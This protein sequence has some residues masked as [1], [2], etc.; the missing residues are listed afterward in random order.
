MNVFRLFEE[1]VAGALGRLADAGDIPAGLAIGRV[2][3]EPPRDPSHG[4]LATN[5]AMVLAKDAKT[6]PRALA[7]KIAA[8]LRGDERVAKVDV[9]GPGFINLTLA[10]GVFLDVLR[11]AVAAGADFGR[12]GVDGPKV[13][14]EYVSAN[15]TGPMHVGHGRGAVF[16][17]ALANLLVFAGRDVTREY[18]INDAGA[19]VD[20]LARSAF[21]R[22]RE[23]LGEDVEIPEGLYPGDYLKPV[24]Q[25]LLAT[26]GP[27]LLE[28]K[29]EAWLPVVRDFAI[30]AMMDMIRA[31]LA[32]LDIRHDVFFSERALSRGETDH[33]AAT[34][35][36]LRAR[37]LVYDGRLP[38]P[39][40]QAVEDW[41]DREQTLFRATNFGDDVD[42]PLLKSDGSYT[43]FAAD[44]AYHRSKFE[45]GCPEM[46]D[47]WGADHGGYVKR[48]QAA[49]RAVTEGRGELDV[50][51]CQLVRLLR[52][53]EPVK[54]SKRAGDFVTLREVVDE[55]GRDAVR[56]MMLYRKNDA[57]LDF[58]LAKVVEQSKDNPVFYVQYAH[59]R[60][61]SIFRQA[62]E[63][64][65][66]EPFG[67]Q[68]LLAADLARLSDEAEVEILR[69]IAAFPRLVEGSA[70]AHEPHRLA[71][72]LYDLASSFHHLWN[73]GKDQ[74]H[75]RFVN[76]TE[77]ESTLARLAL[78]HAVR[79]V[80][81]AGLSVLGVTAPDEMR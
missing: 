70:H 67:P 21:L 15:P 46:I 69:K 37:D 74:P 17:D 81:A 18:Y 31:D 45:R 61:A 77:R 78:V 58:D 27:G 24:G 52:A 51:L 53:G 23:A 3:V 41:E 28:Q 33:I 72:Y 19:Q 60:C 64:F 48:M 20:V 39:K 4:D 55:V 30:D 32:A 68:A 2:V 80:I 79:C 63:A 56:F 47:V 50:K 42:R 36:D 22:Y 14:V 76:Q 66:G 59:A 26:H 75:L 12:G 44:I 16:G 5:A 10:P 54:M 7:D 73:K 34:I 49:V 38:P 43:Y 40:G 62:S 11:A 29:E 35:A 6:N 8:D 9:A 25:A 57:T 1:R 71:F 65:P 13:N